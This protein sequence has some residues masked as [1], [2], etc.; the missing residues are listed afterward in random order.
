M[1][2]LLDTHTV[3]WLIQGDT[4]LSDRARS[5]IESPDTKLYFSDALC[6]DD[7]QS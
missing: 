1:G 2:F 3:L 7:R 6:S 4:N 5:I